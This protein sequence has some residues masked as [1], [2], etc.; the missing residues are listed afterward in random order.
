MSPPNS[1]TSYLPMGGHFHSN[2]HT[3]SNGINDI[4]KTDLM[5]SKIQTHVSLTKIIMCKITG[6]QG[7]QYH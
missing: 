2:H 4:T 5:L 6:L 1:A 7:S 3:E